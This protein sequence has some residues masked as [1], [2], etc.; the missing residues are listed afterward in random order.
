MGEKTVVQMSEV[1][2]GRTRRSDSL[3]DLND[4]HF[5]PSDILSRQIT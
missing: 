2:I 5:F 3:I 4:V 1:A